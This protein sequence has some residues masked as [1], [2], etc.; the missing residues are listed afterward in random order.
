MFDLNDCVNCITSKAV[1]TISYRIEK[2]IA[3]LN[4]TRVQWMALYYIDRE[5]KLTQKELA[6][7]MASKEATIARLIDR[8]VKEGLVKRVQ[9]ETDKRKNYIK[10]TNKGSKIN[11]EASLIV[12]R[13]KDQTIKD[14]PDK[15]LDTFKRVLQMMVENTN[16]ND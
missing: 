5:K 3:H 6:L 11:H 12:E 16:Y 4:I 2:K 10:L 7:A 8:M 15:D 1:K 9:T 14:I 13:F